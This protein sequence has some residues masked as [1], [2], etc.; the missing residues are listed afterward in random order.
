[1]TGNEQSSDAASARSKSGRPSQIALEV[2]QRSEIGEVIP[3]LKLSDLR[4]PNR[5][6][7]WT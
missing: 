2:K 3:I 6:A 5:G 7:R 4:L 1:L